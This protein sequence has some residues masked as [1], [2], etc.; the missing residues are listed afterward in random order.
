MGWT[1]ESNQQFSNLLEV[2][3]EK[4]NSF[5]LNHYYFKFGEMSEPD[6]TSILMR[7]QRYNNQNLFDP[8]DF[9]DFLLVRK[10]PFRLFF[11]PTLKENLKS[12]LFHLKVI[13]KLNMYS[14]R[15]G[16]GKRGTCREYSIWRR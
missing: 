14:T 10:I 5:H 6:R 16:C 12:N 7:L 9:V 2:G 11:I 15:K 4:I 8:F 1:D 13:L 3:F